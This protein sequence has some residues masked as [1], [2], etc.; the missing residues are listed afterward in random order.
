MRR[1]AA[2]EIRDSVLM[3]TGNLNPKMGGPSVFPELPEEVLATASRP[4][5][6]WGQSTPEEANR[7]SVYVKVKRSLLV[8]IL[9]QFDQANTDS[10][11]PVRFSTTVPTQSLTM[12]NGKFINDNALA[13]ANR[14]RYEG[15]EDLEEQVQFGLRHVLCREPEQVEIQHALTFMQELQQHDSVSSEVALNR[16]A[17]L[18]LNLNEFI[19]LD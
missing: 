18:A 8:P 13:F 4:R 14:M 7:R 2:E 16:F 15:G 1:L 19:F 5:N 10:T 12:L 6:V 17:L 9:N 11:C 3:I